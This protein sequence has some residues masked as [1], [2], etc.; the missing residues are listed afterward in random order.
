[1]SFFYRAM[2]TLGL[3]VLAL[4]PMVSGLYTRAKVTVTLRPPLICGLNV[5][6]M[7][8]FCSLC[9]C[10][11]GHWAGCLA[12]SFWLCFHCCLWWDGNPTLTMCEHS[13]FTYWSQ[14]CHT[15]S[16][17]F[18]KLLNTFVICDSEWHQ[19]GSSSKFD[20]LY[21]RICAGVL[22]LFN[23]SSYLCSSWRCSPLI[24]RDRQLFI[25]QV[26]FVFLFILF[27]CART[28]SP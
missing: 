7:S 26:I 4:W 17:F 16:S 23:L 5:F 18:Y 15:Q 21:C 3:V 12:V 10:S 25:F 6:L 1:M 28:F 14:Y 13:L 20:V 24:R 8:C 9:C 11:S 27:H 2:L 19:K 22:T